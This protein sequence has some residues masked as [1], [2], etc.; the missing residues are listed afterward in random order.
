MIQLWVG[1]ALLTLLALSFIFVPF[2]QAKKVQ[3]AAM[4]VD[5]TRQNIEIFEERLS[6]LEAERV[7]G[8]LQEKDYEEL[9]LELE[10]NLL[11]DASDEVQSVTSSS[12]GSKQLVA[13]VLMALLIPISAFG[14][15][16]QHGS[17][18]QLQMSMEYPEQLRF[19]NG[20][21]PT[22]EEAIQM[23]VSELQA[24]PQNAEGWYILAT[25]YMNL[26][27]FDKGVA[28]FKQVLD[29]LPEDATQYVGVMG[30]YAQGLYF[31]KGGKMDEEVRQQIKLTLDREPLEVT[32]LGLLGIDAFEQNRLEDAVGFWRKALQNA[33]PDAADSLK[34]GIQRAL[35]QLAQQ[36]KPVPDV[37]ELAIAS[38][39]LSVSIDPQL[40]DNIAAD[41]VVFVFAKPVGG[42]IPVAAVRLTVGELPTTI[43]LDDSLAM[44]PQAKLSLHPNVEIGARISMSGQPQAASGDLE[45]ATVLVAVKELSEPVNLV[46]DRIVD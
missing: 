15:Y 45:S 22:V 20:E 3:S 27:E 31:A 36:G 28:S 16:F 26:G 33:E 2:I 25:T 17:A 42:R 7:A 9:K 8:N 24:N 10:K 12:I 38:I 5:R 6:E 46:I 34:A 23:L 30:Q 21:Q 4:N 35:E 14:L 43:S 41:Q 44:T 19:E 32:A 37:P 29:I 40:G 18:H 39:Q 1:I 13:V 11:E